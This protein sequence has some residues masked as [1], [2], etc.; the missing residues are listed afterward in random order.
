MELGGRRKNSLYAKMGHYSYSLVDDLFMPIDDLPFQIRKGHILI[1]K[2]TRYKA[3]F[4]LL[5]ICCYITFIKYRISKF[6][7]SYA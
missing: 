7:P 1:F 2:F 5:K 4:P 6:I 3:K